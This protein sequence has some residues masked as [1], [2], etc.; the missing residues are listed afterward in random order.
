[1]SAL[2]IAAISLSFVWLVFVLIIAVNTII[3][4]VKEI[5]DDK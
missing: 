5:G 3:D 1:M 2:D 4:L